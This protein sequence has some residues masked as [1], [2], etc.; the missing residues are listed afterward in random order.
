MEACWSPPK[1]LPKILLHT[2]T[3]IRRDYPSWCCDSITNKKEKR[4][5]DD[6]LPAQELRLLKLTFPPEV[7]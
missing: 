4:K 7:L 5:K 6:F 2:A 3:K 1:Y